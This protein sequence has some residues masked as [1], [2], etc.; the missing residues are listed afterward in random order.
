[1]DNELI[2]VEVCEPG[3]LIVSGT[4]ELKHADGRV[5][6]RKRNTAFCRCGKSGNQP[7][8]DGSHNG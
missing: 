3:P 5:E 4:I 1:M 2:K 7:L 6:I 8:C